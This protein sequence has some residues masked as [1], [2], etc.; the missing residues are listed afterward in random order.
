VP[1]DAIGSDDVRGALHDSVSR[2][3]MVVSCATLLVNSP[4][5]PLDMSEG[6]SEVLE[7]VLRV[8]WLAASANVSGAARTELTL[9]DTLPLSGVAETRNG[10]DLLS[11]AVDKM[12]E[13]LTD[14]D[15]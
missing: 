15:L 1:V 3:P 11:E 6:V 13:P 9:T 7:E 5:R 2:F 4:Y 12:I 10:C 14:S 8:E